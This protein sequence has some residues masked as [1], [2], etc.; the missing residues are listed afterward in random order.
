LSYGFIGWS[1][2]TD[3]ESETYSVAGVNAGSTPPGAISNAYT[4]ITR[5]AR[6]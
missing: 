1:P 3:E 6:G 2:E 4:P 5:R